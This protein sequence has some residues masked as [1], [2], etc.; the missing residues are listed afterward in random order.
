MV[1]RGPSHSAKARENAAEYRAMV[2]EGV[3][4]TK[5]GGRG[6]RNISSKPMPTA[7]SKRWSHPGE[8]P[9][10]SHE[11]RMAPTIDAAPLRPLVLRNRDRGRPERLRAAR[12][13]RPDSEQASRAHRNGFACP[14]K[15]CAFAEEKILRAG[16]V[17]LIS[18]CL[19]QTVVT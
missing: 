9:S 12:T 14:P 6:D 5:A 15:R 4:S 3:N 16:A 10:V 17:T 18:C 7:T 19:R 2:A 8:I 11:G 13:K 1:V